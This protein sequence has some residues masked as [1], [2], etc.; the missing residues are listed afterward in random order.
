MGLFCG[1]TPYI[2]HQVFIFT[3]DSD[4]KEIFVELIDALASLKKGQYI[5]K[6]LK[7]TNI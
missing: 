1:H 3:I 7:L 5:I 2:S 6:H 4:L